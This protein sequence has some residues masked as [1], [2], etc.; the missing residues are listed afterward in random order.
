ML[1][2]VFGNV[3]VCVSSL[4]CSGDE[5]SC[6]P[7]T[8]SPTGLLTKSSICCLETVI[9]V[10]KSITEV[11]GSSFTEASLITGLGDL[12]LITCTVSL[13]RLFL[14]G[15]CKLLFVWGAL[16]EAGRIRSKMHTW[17][18]NAMC[19]CSPPMQTLES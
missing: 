11:K 1:A 6:S 3:V 13:R 4:R 5:Q 8:D 19:F 10:V 12:L 7:P 18:P 16:C 9:E 14:G 2:Q 17:S 15:M